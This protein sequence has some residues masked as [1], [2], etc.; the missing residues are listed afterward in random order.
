MVAMTA[1]A[2]VVVVLRGS[3]AFRS[4][5]SLRLIKISQRYN[6]VSARGR[7]WIPSC[8]NSIHPTPFLRPSLTVFYHLCLGL[9]ASG[10][11][12]KIS[13]SRSAAAVVMTNINTSSAKRYKQAITR[14]ELPT[15][16]R[17]DRFTFDALLFSY[18]SSGT[19]HK[20][21]LTV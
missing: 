5:Q 18:S 3:E 1:A 12:I 11:T 19:S 6:T 8:D 16:E 20:L 10:F 17:C 14:E 7:Y 4:L 9:F 13:S 21:S 15:I 2:A